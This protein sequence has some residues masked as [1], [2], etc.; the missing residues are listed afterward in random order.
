[1]SLQWNRN[2]VNFNNG[3]VSP[4]PR[5]VQEAMRRYL[6]YRTWSISTP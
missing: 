1:M 5:V 2:L 4:A 6:E 3:H